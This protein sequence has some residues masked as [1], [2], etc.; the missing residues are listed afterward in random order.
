MTE[1][2]T[3]TV[4]LKDLFAKEE[5]TLDNY[6]RFR[7]LALSTEGN[8][9]ALEELA[10]SLDAS[11][12]KSATKKGIALW[13]LGRVRPALEALE[14]AHP[15]DETASIFLGRALLD[16]EDWKK[17]KLRFRE[18]LAAHKDSRP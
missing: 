18:G 13:L 11:Q 7:E 4:D 16:L 2:T 5:L 3:A 17:A 10:T 8:A 6:R 1:G 9:K 14:R 12:K 15:D